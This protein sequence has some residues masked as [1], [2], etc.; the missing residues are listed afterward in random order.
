MNS[1]QPGSWVN[2]GDEVYRDRLRARKL[3]EVERARQGGFGKWLKRR[4]I[5]LC[6]PDWRAARWVR[7]LVRGVPG[8][9]HSAFPM[10]D[11]VDELIRY[12]RLEEDFNRILRKA[13]VEE[14][15]SIPHENATPGKKAY[16]EYYT[17]ELQQ[18]ME[19]YLGDQMTKF[20]YSLERPAATV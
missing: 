6:R 13:G 18:L 4:L 16:Y 2:A 19:R 12:E 11:G 17:P 1:T 20:G 7:N 9:R 14:F 5:R 10:I 8:N 3:A 15:I